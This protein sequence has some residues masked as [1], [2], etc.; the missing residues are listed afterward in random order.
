MN[1][2]REQSTYK[3]R[4]GDSRLR[5]P[6]MEYVK[7]IAE[8]SSV[9]SYDGRA[10]P[11]DEMKTVLTAGGAAPV[12]MGKFESVHLTVVRDP[13]ALERI[14]AGI[15]EV[16]AK[17]MGRENKGPFDFYGAST[18]VIIS[19]EATDLPGSDFVNAGGIAENMMLQAAKDG[20]GS[21]II[22]ATGSVVD[23]DEGMKS[24]LEVPA[25]F[26]PLF[27]VVFGYAVKAPAPKDM[28]EMRVQCNFV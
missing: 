27:G 12:G 22:W 10:V 25:G 18:L 5:R 3:N 24:D 13:K 4:V 15:S 28:G 6:T 23:G 7:A 26:H 20:I 1:S 11:D 14:G 21:C 19:S 16:M 2:S 17:A 8:R 9:R